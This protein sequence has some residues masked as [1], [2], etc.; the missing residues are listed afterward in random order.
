MGDVFVHFVHVAKGVLDVD[1]GFGVFLVGDEEQPG[2]E[3]AFVVYAAGVGEGT[4]QDV[5]AGGVR[6]AGVRGFGHRRF[7]LV[8][9]EAKVDG[10]VFFVLSH[11]RAAV[12]VAAKGV[13]LFAEAGAIPGF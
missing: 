13:V 6:D 4:A 11:R 9:F 2:V 5:V 3:L 12:A 7:A 8:V 1:E 10:F